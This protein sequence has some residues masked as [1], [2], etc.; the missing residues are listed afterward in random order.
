MT[1]FDMLVLYPLT[2]PQGALSYL[3]LCRQR[4][5]Q[6]WA[7]SPRPNPATVLLL[8]CHAVS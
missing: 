2:Q 6:D 3:G 5:V 7:Q 4:E 1:Y 8:I